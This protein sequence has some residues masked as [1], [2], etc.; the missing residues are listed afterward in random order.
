MALLL[1]NFQNHYLTMS[2]IPRLNPQS[3][4]LYCISIRQKERL[5]KHI[6]GHKGAATEALSGRR[7]ISKAQAK[8]LA[9]FFRV[10]IDLFI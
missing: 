10:P 8:R 2:A 6:V 4:A 3:P 1:R 7:S 9:E 5:G